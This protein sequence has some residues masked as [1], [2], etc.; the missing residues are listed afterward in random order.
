MNEPLGC[1]TLFARK[2][3]SVLIEFNKSISDFEVWIL[4]FHFYSVLV[5][6]NFCYYYYY[7]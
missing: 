6:F 5:P 3:I 7:Y 4:K 2:A 1:D